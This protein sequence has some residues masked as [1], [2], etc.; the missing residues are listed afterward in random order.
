[1][2]KV[3]GR[4]TEYGWIQELV[5]VGLWSV[6]FWQKLIFWRKVLRNGREYSWQMMWWGRGLRPVR[7]ENKDEL[8]E[9]TKEQERIGDMMKMGLG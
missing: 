3:Q 9:G 7:V 5:K 1:M 2:N 6:E 8:G 4:A